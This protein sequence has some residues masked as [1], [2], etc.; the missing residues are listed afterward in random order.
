MQI[1]YPKRSHMRQAYLYNPILPPPLF[2]FLFDT[3][4]ALW[5]TPPMSTPHPKLALICRGVIPVRLEK[6][7]ICGTRRT[8]RPLPITVRL[9]LPASFVI[10]REG[11]RCT[12]APQP[13][14]ALDLRHL[15]VD[16]VA[17]VVAKAAGARGTATGL[18]GRGAPGEVAVKL[19]EEDLH[20]L[21]RH[22]EFVVDFGQ[23]EIVEDASGLRRTGY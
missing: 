16:P 19:S 9:R 22:D 6:L 1:L 18:P 2:L 12:G 10:A 3:L 7:H 4:D 23:T 5:G 8:R 17:P 20:G 15:C 21:G 14:I 11:R 13:Y